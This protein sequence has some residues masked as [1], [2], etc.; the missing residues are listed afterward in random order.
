[1]AASKTLLAHYGVSSRILLN[2]AE[3]IVVGRGPATAAEDSL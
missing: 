2:G 3:G 1:M